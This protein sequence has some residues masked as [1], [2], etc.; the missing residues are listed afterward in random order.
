[1]KPETKPEK[2]RPAFYVAGATG[3]TG[4]AVVRAARARGLHTV[5]HVRPDS[6]SLPRW[7]ETFGA[8]GATVD[9]TPW[10]LDALTATMARLCPTV[11]FGLLGTTRKRGAS[12]GGTY[13]TVDYGLTAMLID[14]A[15]AAGLRP[16]FVYLSAL[17]VAP[18]RSPEGYLGVRYRLEQ[19]LVAAGLPFVIAR[20]AIITGP[21]RGED[22]PGERI[23]AVV[24]DA[25]LGAVSR[26]G[27]RGLA[28]KYAST[29]AEI[30][31][32]ALVR[33]AVDPAATALF[34]EG[35]ALR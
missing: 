23:G 12:D 35:E 27:G 1:M 29:T 31:G 34:A 10:A 26:L 30:L 24:G 15:L 4:Q 19:K 7:R 32:G 16:K 14:A 20:P 9:S 17:G 11:V 28:S 8:M 3:Y 13:A 33:L 6:S 22:R 2:E 21:D 5:A 25:L 18:G